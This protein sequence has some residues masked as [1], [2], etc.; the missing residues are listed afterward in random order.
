MNINQE[1][2]AVTVFSRRRRAVV[3]TFMTYAGGGMGGRL[4]STS[5]VV[6]DMGYC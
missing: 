1:R 4:G 5:W 2:G 6:I 3:N